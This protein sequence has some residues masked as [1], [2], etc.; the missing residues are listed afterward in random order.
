VHELDSFLKT[1][2]EEEAEDSGFF[3]SNKSE[4]RDDTQRL[5]FTVTLDVPCHSNFT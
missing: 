4:I 2:N 1:L 3:A 5:G